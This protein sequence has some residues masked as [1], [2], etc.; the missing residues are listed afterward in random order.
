M[1]TNTTPAEIGKR[2]FARR[3]QL[4]ITQEALADAVETTPQIISNY[5][6]GEREL[7][8]GAIVRIAAALHVSVDFL[9]AGTESVGIQLSE[10]LGTQQKQ[11]LRDIIE[12]FL[13]FSKTDM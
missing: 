7:K 1:E 10:S 2:I 3:R 12:K 6:R 5:E 9:L 4:G 11:Q 8:A 13:T